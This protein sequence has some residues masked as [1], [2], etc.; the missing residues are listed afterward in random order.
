MPFL[1]RRKK[2]KIFCIIFCGSG[3]KSRFLAIW[4]LFAHTGYFVGLSHLLPSDP[5]H[6][7]IIPKI[8]VYLDQSGWDA[9]NLFMILS[10][11]VI[12]YLIDQGNENYFPYLI[13][14]FLRLW[15]V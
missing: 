1:N 14:R 15:P 11:F 7:G 8:L 2:T 9:V 10:G 5:W 13:R 4:V 12:S 6:P 3:A